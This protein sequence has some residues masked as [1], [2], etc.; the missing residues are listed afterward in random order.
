MSKIIKQNNRVDL[1]KKLGFF[2]KQNKAHKNEIRVMPWGH[3]INKQRNK[4]AH[5]PDVPNLFHGWHKINK[6]DTDIPER[7]VRVVFLTCKKV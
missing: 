2:L 1:E 4:I 5:T 3:L 6:N 7:Q